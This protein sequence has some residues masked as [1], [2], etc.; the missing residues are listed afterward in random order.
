MRAKK[1]KVKNEP[2]WNMNCDVDINCT[3]KKECQA[4]KLQTRPETSPLFPEQN[5]DPA[6]ESS[7][8]GHRTRISESESQATKQS[9]ACLFKHEFQK[10]TFKDDVNSGVD[11]RLTG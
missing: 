1:S 8:S 3:L 10:H 7:F 2:Q 4:S 5:P 11:E 9:N 6:L